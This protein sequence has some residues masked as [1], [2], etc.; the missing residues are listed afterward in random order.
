MNVPVTLDLDHV[1]CHVTTRTES[2]TVHVRMDM[3]FYQI[4]SAVEVWK[5]VSKIYFGLNSKASLVVGPK[6]D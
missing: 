3:D 4:Q 6:T 5:Y 1:R 2:S